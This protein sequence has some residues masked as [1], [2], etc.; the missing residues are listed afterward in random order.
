MTC[1]I[2]VAVLISWTDVSAVAGTDAAKPTADKMV[3]ETLAP[4][5]VRQL[6]VM[7]GNIFS[8]QV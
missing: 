4:I 3:A 8:L 1:L 2:G 6:F 7:C 5:F